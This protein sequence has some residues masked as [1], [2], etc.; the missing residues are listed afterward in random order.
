MVETVKAADP[1]PASKAAEPPASKA[2]DPA[3]ASK[4]AKPPASKAAEPAPASKAAEPAPA[5][6]AINPVQYAR[7]RYMPGDPLDLPQDVLAA[8]VASGDA[9]VPY[10]GPVAAGP[11]TEDTPDGVA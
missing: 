7:K 6:V 1:A 11:D 5:C 2:A 10:A 9:K 8:L 3:P 4:A